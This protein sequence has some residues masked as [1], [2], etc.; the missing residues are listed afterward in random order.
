[1][2]NLSVILII[3]FW[4]KDTKEKKGKTAKE[5]EIIKVS[6]RNGMR[7]KAMHLCLSTVWETPSFK[8]RNPLIHVI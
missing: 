6:L 7:V 5:I 1:M 8:S 4:K 2:F 3:H